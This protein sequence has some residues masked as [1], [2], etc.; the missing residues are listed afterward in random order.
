MRSKEL[1]TFTERRQ[2]KDQLNQLAV[3]L[4]IKNK[5]CPPE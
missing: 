4:L 2:I 3:S 5:Y 1:R